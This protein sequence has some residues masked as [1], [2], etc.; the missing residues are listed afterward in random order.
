MVRETQLRPGTRVRIVGKPVGIR[1][2]SSRGTVVGPDDRLEG[3]YI[4]RLDAPAVSSEPSDEGADVPE[5]VEYWDN[6]DL[7]PQDR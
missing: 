6:L 5:I 1:L 7:L 2:R 3:Y 4:V